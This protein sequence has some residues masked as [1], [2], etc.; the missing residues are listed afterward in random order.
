LGKVYLPLSKSV[1][2]VVD[3]FNDT[4]VAEYVH[5]HG[6]PVPADIDGAEEEDSL[7][8]PAHGHLQYQLTPQAAGSRWVHSHA[9]AMKDLTVGLYGGQF[10]FVYV[11][12]K[13]NPGRYD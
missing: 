6:F 3:I 4:D 1:P 5:W 11:E 8:V 13:N 12:P 10:G 7:I 9:M 2:V